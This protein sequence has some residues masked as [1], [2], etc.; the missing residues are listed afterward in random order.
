MH[1]T[2]TKTET[3][4]LFLFLHEL[5]SDDDDAMRFTAKDNPT[6]RAGLLQAAIA[7]RPAFPRLG[8]VRPLTAW[9]QSRNLEFLALIGVFFK[10]TDYL[11]VA[12]FFFFF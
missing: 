11:C 4:Y 1:F 8:G 5:Y 6:D 2:F 9:A 12:F 10:I 3:V 7:T